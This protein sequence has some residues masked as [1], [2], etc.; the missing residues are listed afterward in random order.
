MQMMMDSPADG[1]AEGFDYGEQKYYTV[2]KLRNMFQNA[3]K[4]DLLLTNRY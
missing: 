2:Q 3:A 4:Q 1:G